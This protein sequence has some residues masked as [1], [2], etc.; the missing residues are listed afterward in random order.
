MRR[1]DFVTLAGGMVELPNGSIMGKTGDGC[2][3]LFDR[4]PRATGE[5]LK[6]QRAILVRSPRMR[7][8]SRG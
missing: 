7:V 6:W 5:S 1:R 4:Q 8:S 2:A 3:G